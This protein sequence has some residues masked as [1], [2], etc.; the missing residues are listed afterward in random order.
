MAKYSIELVSSKGNTFRDG[1]KTLTE[2]RVKA[3]RLI[4]KGDVWIANIF[5]TTGG[6]YNKLIEQVFYDPVDRYDD[7]YLPRSEGYYI[8]IYSDPVKK[9]KGRRMRV[10]PKTG[11]LLD[12]NREWKSL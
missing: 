2:T 6:Y 9:K 1:G 3:C 12:F 4:G 8:Q 7:K 10:S 11:R 5:E